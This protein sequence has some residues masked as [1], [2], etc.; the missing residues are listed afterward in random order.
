[1]KVSTVLSIL[2]GIAVVWVA[3]AANGYE[4]DIEDLRALVKQNAE[5]VDSVARAAA[6]HTYVIDSL[7]KSMKD[8]ATAAKGNRESLIRIEEK[9]RIRQPSEGSSDAG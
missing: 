6:Q 8:A 2:S 5:Q 1:M 9:L 7:E 4:K 3:W